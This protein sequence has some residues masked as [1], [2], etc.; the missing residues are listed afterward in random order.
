MRTKGLLLL[1]L[2][3]VLVL[4]VSIV[5]AW[6]SYD[7]YDSHPWQS[8]DLNYKTQTYKDTTEYKRTTETGYKDRWNDE[9][10]KTTV[11]EKTEYS[12]TTKRPDYRTD[13]YY[14]YNSPSYRY[15]DRDDKYRDYGSS[16]RYK[17]PYSEWKQTGKDDYYY[18]PRYDTYLGYYNWRY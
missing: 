18:K 11:T 15:N 13:V 4:S 8:S 10:L 1:S 17:E 9:K 12:I 7:T 3:L 16:W 2:V 5:S 14:G 6:E